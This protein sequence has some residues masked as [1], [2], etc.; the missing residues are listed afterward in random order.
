MAPDDD[1]GPDEGE[2]I[3]GVRVYDDGSSESEYGDGTL[4]TEEADGSTVLE[5]PDGTETHL[6]APLSRWEEFWMTFL[7]GRRVVYLSG[8]VVIVGLGLGIGLSGY[9]DSTATAVQ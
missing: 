4:I 5:F 2:I 1:D 8:A 6:P 7:H 3:D 9:G